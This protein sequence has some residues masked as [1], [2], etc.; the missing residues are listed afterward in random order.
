LKP[1]ELTA[2]QIVRHWIAATGTVSSL[3]E[4]DNADFE[5]VYLNGGSALGEIKS[6]TNEAAKSQWE[7]I[8]K[9]PKKQSSPIAE[10]L[11]SWSFQ[12]S[13][14]TSIKCLI[15]NANTLV[16][17]LKNRGINEWTQ[18]TGNAKNGTDQLLI[19]LSVEVAL[20]NPSL[21]SDE[22]WIQPIEGFREWPG[23]PQDANC[24]IPWIAE[25]F[26]IDEWQKSWERLRVASNGEG[27]VFI[28]IDSDSPHQLKQRRMFHPYEPPTEN[29]EL[30]NGVTHL[31]IGVSSCFE[32]NSIAWLYIKDLGWQ[33][34]LC[35]II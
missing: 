19:Q 27:H 25:I 29:P 28:W 16:T 30:I 22:L 14:T 5:I 2:I 33:T 26:A 20:H 18:I 7:A 15:E 31:W 23:I 13:N 11:G 1:S 21:N 24:A 3:G 6:D 32:G 9:L 17:D 12:I 10:G 8:N 34:V 35:P 4:G